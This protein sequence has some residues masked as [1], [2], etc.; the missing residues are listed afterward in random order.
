MSRV[1][2]SVGLGRIL[3]GQRLF[4]TCGEHVLPV[5]R[6]V[7]TSLVGG[8][9]RGAVAGSIL[10]FAIRRPGFDP[11]S[12]SPADPRATRSPPAARSETGPAIRVGSDSE[13]LA[14]PAARPSRRGR[15]RIN[16]P[17]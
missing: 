7:A 12:A 8:V 13:Q 5:A 16:G 11:A 4:R 14:S 15:Q 10:T 3:V 9:L 6:M 17:C 1:T 2:L